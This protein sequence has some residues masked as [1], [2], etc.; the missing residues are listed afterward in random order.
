MLRAQEILPKIHGVIKQR[1]A[2]MS[3]LS[4]HSESVPSRNRHC[5]KG[6]MAVRRRD[7]TAEMQ[8]EAQDCPSTVHGSEVQFLV[9]QVDVPLGDV[10]VKYLAN[11]ATKRQSTD[12]STC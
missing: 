7:M 10:F 11:P 4:F 9:P 3:S 12:H 2:S 5:G 6:L 8:M 1:D